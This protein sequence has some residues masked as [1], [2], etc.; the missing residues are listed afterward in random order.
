LYNSYGS[1]VTLDYAAYQSANSSSSSSGSSFGGGGLRV[2]GNSSF[3]RFKLVS[4]LVTKIAFK[5]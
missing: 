4:L 2:V 5:K 1:I 3:F